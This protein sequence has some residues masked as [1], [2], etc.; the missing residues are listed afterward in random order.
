[1][2]DAFNLWSKQT[3]KI[4]HVQE[5]NENGPVTED[6][7][8]ARRMNKNLQAF[9]SSEGFTPD[10]VA[11]KLENVRVKNKHLMLKCLT[12]WQVSR[13]KKAQIYCFDRIVLWVKF[14]K[15][16]KEKL[17]FCHNS[18]SPE[19]CDISQAFKMWVRKDKKMESYLETFELKDVMTMSYNQSLSL[20]YLAD[21]EAERQ[22]NIDL[23]K[24]QRDELLEHYI[25]AQRLAIIVL[26]DHHRKS[27]L[28][29]F[30]SWSSFTEKAASGA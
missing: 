22:V 26:R 29:A 11:E 25:R 5:I 15:L 4:A 7:F 12:R 27:M 3:S 28:S 23:F 24:A 14:R 16:M 17:R 1:L 21:E 6:V 8:E 18:V 9:M 2:R 10:E 30:K 13:E 20:E 19:L